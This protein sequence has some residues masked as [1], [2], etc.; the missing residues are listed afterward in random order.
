MI[1]YKIS[2]VFRPKIFWLM[3]LLIGCKKSSTPLIGDWKQQSEFDGVTRTDAVSFVINNTAYVGTGFNAS[4]NEYYRDFWK[5]NP[6]DNFW[7]QIADFPGVPRSGAVAFTVN[8][9]GY[10]GTGYDGID[11]HKDF[12][13]YD[14]D[15]NQWTQKN[16]FEGTARYGAVAFGVGNY[17]YVGTGYD[18]NDEKDFWQYD[19][20]NDTWT[21]IP[22][23][24]GTK[25]QRAVTFVLGKDAYVLC[26]VHNGIYPTDVW[27][28][29]TDQVGSSGFPWSSKQALDIN[30]NYSIVRSG[31][32]A[33]VLDGE[34]YVAIGRTAAY[35]TTTWHYIPSNDTWEQK[36]GWEG[37]ARDGAISF[38][39]NGRAFV[40]LGS[41][42]SL[43]FDD[44]WEWLPNNQVDSND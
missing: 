25:R 8:G 32:V 33:M 44:L 31:A 35:V 29:H 42:G 17:G 6:T 5:Y 40:G 27:V 21:Q 12:W 34:A 11:S 4:T 38:V 43:Y 9:K 7:Q 22:S 37:T 10:V 18:G 28:L 41:N 14:P 19:P 39:A 30:T 24:G 36:T 26:G 13:E 2:N 1:K 3:L 23:L 16:D 15:K 20:S